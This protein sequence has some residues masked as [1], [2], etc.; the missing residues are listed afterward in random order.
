MAGTFFRTIFFTNVRV[1]ACSGR[2]FPGGFLRAKL[3]E[4]FLWVIAP[5][6]FPWAVSR[7][8]FPCAFAGAFPCALWQRHFYTHSSGWS[9]SGSWIWCRFFI[10]VNDLLKFNFRVILMHARVRRGE[11]LVRDLRFNLMVISF[12]VS[13]I[14]PN[15]WNIA[16]RWNS[17][18]SY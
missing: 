17:E 10:E 18:V 7:G 14:V 9:L 16:P 5:G 12:T 3:K 1:D 13:V 15:W 6:L 11:Y 8:L 4:L 2:H